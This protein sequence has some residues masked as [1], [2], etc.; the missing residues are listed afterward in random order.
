MQ[1]CRK[2]G[3]WQTYD[4]VFHQSVWEGT[5][6]VHPGSITLFFNG[7]LVQDHWELDGLT[8]HS[9]RRPLASHK[10][11]GPLLLQDHGCVVHF[12]NVWIR[13][14]P[15]LWDNLTHGEMSAKTDAVMAQRKAT[16]AE[17]NETK[18]K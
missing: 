12:R 1:P 9:R 15:S 13:P 16:A 11:K 8:T 3:E 7:V 2:P 5:T 6:L 4:I 18:G 10:T 17:E 14:L